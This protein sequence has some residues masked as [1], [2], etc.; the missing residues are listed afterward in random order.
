MIVKEVFAKLGLEIDELAFA[1]GEAVMRALSKGALAIG[2]AAVSGVAVLGA[3]FTKGFADAADHA[4]KLAQSTG[5]DSIALQQL[6]Y[7]ANLANVSTEELAQ[8]LRHLAKTGVT[9]VRG[10]VEELAD[11]FSKMPDNGAKVARAMELFGRSGARLIP[12]LNGGKEAIHE[13]MLEAET[14]GV[15]LSED[16]QKAGEAF[17][18]ELSRVMFALAGIRNE[19]GRTLLPLVSK[20]ATG[21]LKFVKGLRTTREWVVKATAAF[22]LL[23]IALLSVGSALLLLSKAAA[24]NAF[25]ANVGILINVFRALGFAAISTAVKAAAAWAAAALPFLVITAAIG[26]V[27]LWL[28]DLYT[29]LRG[30]DSVI[31]DFVKELKQLDFSKI[32]TDGFEALKR[33]VFGV[34][35]SIVDYFKSTLERIKVLFTSLG[36]WMA[37]TPFFSKMN[38]LLEGLSL[39]PG[40]SII[41]PIATAVGSVAR[42]SA[43]AVSVPQIPFSPTQPAVPG[44]SVSANVSFYL[45]PRLGAEEVAAQARRQLD[46]WWGNITREAEAGVP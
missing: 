40:G 39:L 29:F 28:E 34:F 22:K 2:A 1:K 45:D 10:R 9:D 13:L 5:V 11:E 18:D 31:G 35:D 15:V 44:N 30:G 23:T 42:A 37:Q 14:L 27:L 6:A 33:A 7:A 17:N 43:P 26:I 41:S 25:I 32:L 46:S 3:A 12:M 20:L 16:D 21:F 8:G 19:I 24:L 38:M 4:G 36:D